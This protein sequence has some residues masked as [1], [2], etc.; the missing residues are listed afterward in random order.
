MIKIAQVCYSISTGD[1]VSGQVLW[2]DWAFKKL[3]YCAEI[4]CYRYTEDIGHL[5]PFTDLIYDKDTIVIY[6][7]SCGNSLANK[8]L[9]YPG[10]ILLYYHNITPAHFF[11][12]YS[13]GNLRNCLRGR[14]QLGKLRNNTMYAW[15]ASEYS[16]QELL[17][18]KYSKT[19]VLPICVDYQA[20]YQQPEDIQLVSRYKDGKLNILF[21]GRV[22]PHKKQEDLIKI[23]AYYK[24]A[25]NKEVRLILVGN[26]KT[27]YQD[28]L[29]QLAK[30]LGVEEDVVFPGKVSF[31]ELCTYYRLS[32]LFLCMSEHEGFCIPLIE[33]M[34]FMKPVFAY[35]AAAVAET[36]DNAGVLFHEKDIADIANTISRTMKSSSAL[37]Q[38]N[39]NMK[40]RLTTLDPEATLQKLK[41]DMDDIIETRALSK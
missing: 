29:L 35:S 32:D 1:G 20:Y 15:A 25:I 17:Q 13:W 12:S 9:D 21:V 11:W 30:N 4:Y 40:I 8:I 26:S 7:F 10:P 31:I 6:H 16:R 28:K 14:Y 33:S 18:K 3:G 27:S 41:S 36:V 5:K 22:V 2:M 24:K 39:H 37:A 38:L 34:I 19:S 23:L